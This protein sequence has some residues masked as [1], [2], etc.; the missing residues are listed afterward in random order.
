MPNHWMFLG[1]LEKPIGDGGGRN[2]NGID[3]N[4]LFHNSLPQ[5]IIQG[6]PRKTELCAIFR[7]VRRNS[8]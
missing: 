8:R 1:R 4:T 3:G 2:S 6:C 5:S 7:G